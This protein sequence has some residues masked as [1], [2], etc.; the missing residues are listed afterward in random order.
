M[1]DRGQVGD[2]SEAPPQIALPAVVR[3]KGQS[4]ARSANRHGREACA[5]RD[6]RQRR[7]LD[8]RFTAIEYE[9]LD[10]VRNFVAQVWL[11]RSSNNLALM[12]GTPVSGQSCSCAD[13]V[14]ELEN[15]VDQRLGGGRTARHIDV[16]RH[17]AVGRARP[18]TNSGSSHRRWQEPMEM[19]Q[20]GSDIWS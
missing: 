18:S 8:R 17:D 2:G 3:P 10:P 14:L 5:T 20:R 11:R 19:T 7:H 6:I 16:D 4:A 15:A 13:L 1:P 9:R 12:S